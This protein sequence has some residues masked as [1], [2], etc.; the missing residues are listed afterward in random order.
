MLHISILL[1]VIASIVF[2]D[3]IKMLSVIV[4]LTYIFFAGAFPLGRQC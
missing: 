4:V 2:D 3:I 1:D